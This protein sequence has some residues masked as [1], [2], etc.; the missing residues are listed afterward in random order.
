MSE[1][2]KV[3]IHTAQLPYENIMDRPDDIK[4]GRR[5]RRAEARAFTG[6]T[7]PRA[8]HS[9]PRRRLGFTDRLLRNSAIA[10][11]A[12]LG[13][14]ALGNIRQP[15]AEKAAQGI[16][17]ALTMHIDL[18][19]S[20]GELTFVRELMPESAL[21]FLNVSAA[22]A[23]TSPVSGAVEHPWSNVQP[24]LMLTCEDGTPVVAA[25]AGTVTAVSPMSE[26][27]FGLLIDHGDGVETLYAQMESVEVSAGDT[28][29][30][31]QRLGVSGE[32]LYFEYRENAASIDPTEMLGL[33]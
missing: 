13:I 1:T 10:C 4:P 9:V 7:L 8:G 33:K 27:K 16:E 12:L 20:I 31:G 19:D 14:L 3:K 15:W 5:Q 26:G 11:A 21:V 28:V 24:W 25:A 30:R 22:S 23:L 2:S 32:G 17:Q 6:K 18:D 29:E